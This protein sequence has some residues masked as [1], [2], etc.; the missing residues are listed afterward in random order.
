MEFLAFSEMHFDLGHNKSCK[1]QNNMTSWANIQT[2]IIDQIYNYSISNNIKH[3]FHGGDLFG[4]KNYIPQNLYNLAWNKFKEL[5]ED[6]TIYLNTGN[7]DFHSSVSSSLRPF[8]AICNVITEPTDIHFSNSELIR[9]IPYGMIDK[10]LGTSIPY[11]KKILFTHEDIA[12]LK[13]GPNDYVSGS[14]YKR[15]IFSDWDYVFNGHIHKAQVIGN[16]INMGGC[17]RHNFGEMDKKY[18][19]H[20]KDG[21]VDQIEIKCP[22]FITT[23]GFSPK[24]RQIIEKDNYNFYRI[25]ISSEELSDPLFNKYNV[26]PNIIKSKKKKKRLKSDMT[27][28]EEV[29]KYIEIVDSNLDK[30]K[31]LEFIKEL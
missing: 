5:S 15:Q 26:F 23:P 28:K 11:S 3:I 9:I 18:F 17:M 2:N 27:E 1:L 25:N 13:M 19:Y 21:K 30:N 31:I 6:F 24:I 12:D 16:I 4:K 29:L 22:E 14:R 7:H 8:S 10:N 20:Y